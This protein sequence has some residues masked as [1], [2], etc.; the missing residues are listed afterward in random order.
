MFRAILVKIYE[1]AQNSFLELYYG[2]THGHP[3][4]VHVTTPDHPFV[5]PAQKHSTT[6]LARKVG[7]HYLPSALGITLIIGLIAYGARADLKIASR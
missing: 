3:V 4:E 1:H 6:E 2:H 7:M 5:H